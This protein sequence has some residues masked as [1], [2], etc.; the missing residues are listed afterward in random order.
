LAV[1]LRERLFSLTPSELNLAPTPTRGRVWAALM[2]VALKNGVGTV[3]AV[4]DGSVSLYTSAGGGVIGAG[5][6]LM[7][8]Q[9]ADRF[10]DVAEECLSALATADDHLY[11]VSGHAKLYTLTFSEGVFSA[12]VD[13]SEV[14]RGHPLYA[15]FAAAQDVIS[16]IRETMPTE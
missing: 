3:V 13:T 11:P 7:V 12:E 14:R 2:D 9:A 16:A 6:H 1:D 8:R 5:E 4:G 15:M 10:L